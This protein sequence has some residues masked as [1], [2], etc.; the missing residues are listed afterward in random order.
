M[1]QLKERY[2]KEMV[3]S[4]MKSLEMDNVMQVPRLLKVVVNIGMGE[5]NENPKTLDAAVTDLVTITG[6]KPVITK[7]RKD[8][9]NF[10]L[11][12]GR[13]IGVK[14]T[15]RGERM[16][17]FVDRLLNVVLPRVRDFR[18]VSPDAFDGRGNYTLGLRE[19]L[20]FPEIEYDKID[21]VRG[22]EITMVTTAANDEQATF[23]LRE[24][25]M[26]F[27]KG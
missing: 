9:A 6:Q 23:L 18:G 10:K 7:A 1:N 2:Q 22:M 8:I 4:L 25:G 16:W 17:A 3:P 15:L 12:A 24:L 26:P 20:I 19:Q 27:R 14:V 13:A 21:K 5:A 11:R